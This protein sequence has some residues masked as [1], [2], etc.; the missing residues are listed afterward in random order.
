MRAP[1]GA[2]QFRA[3]QKG[4]R[5]REGPGRHARPGACTCRCARSSILLEALLASFQRVVFRVLAQAQV[6][7]KEVAAIGAALVEQGR[8]WGTMMTASARPSLRRLQ[9]LGAQLSSGAQTLR[10]LHRTS[11]L[12]SA[13]AAAPQ[14]AGESDHFDYLVLGAGSGGLG[15]LG[16]GQRHGQPE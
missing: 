15:Q 3:K 2:N 12:K 11:A 14:P 5:A 9:M 1:A 13:A 16:P 7:V 8:L 4:G 6:M 10:S